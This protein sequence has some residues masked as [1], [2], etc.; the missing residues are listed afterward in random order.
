MNRYV[1]LNLK[2][3][4]GCGGLWFRAQGLHGVYCGACQAIF[5]TFPAPRLKKR[6]G[7]PRRH[8][9]TVQMAGGAK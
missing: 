4:E 2:V 3:C 8:S 1:R 6:P 5:D 7:R 9:C